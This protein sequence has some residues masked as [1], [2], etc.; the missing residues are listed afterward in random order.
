MLVVLSVKD[1]FISLFCDPLGFDKRRRIG[2]N[3]VQDISR[4]YATTRERSGAAALLDLGRELYRWL[5]GSEGWLGSKL[6]A[7]FVLEVRAEPQPDAAGSSV[8]QAPWELLANADGFLAE[9]ALL[10]FAPARRVGA[11]RA[12]APCC[13]GIVA[14]KEIGVGGRMPWIGSAAISSEEKIRNAL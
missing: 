5:D 13:Q 10:R 9:N 11:L 14:D 7:P 3:T 2:T 1:P 12:G 8:L 4:R 6:T